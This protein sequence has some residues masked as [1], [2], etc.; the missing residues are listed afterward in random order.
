MQKRGQS[1]IKKLVSLFAAMRSYNL[2]IIALAQYLS[3]VFIF[4]EGHSALQ[5]ILDYRL[6]LLVVSSSFA[7]A[8]GYLINNFYDKKKD[9]INKPL[10]TYITTQVSKETRLRIY[11]TLNFISV[12]L[13]LFV[14]FKAALF[15]AF[16]IFLLWFYSHKLK[17]YPIIGNLTAA[18]LAILPFFGIL[19][20]YKNF[21]SEIFLFG[22]ALYIVLLVKELIKDLEN[23]AGDFANGYQTIPIVY[24][25]Q[26]SK[27]LSVLLLFMQLLLSTYL[28]N[29][30]DTGLMKYYFY[31]SVAVALIL[32]ICILRAHTKKAYLHIH[33]TIKYWLVIGVLSIMLL[34]PS[35]ILHG[36]KVVDQI[37]P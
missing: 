9:L 27:K 23:L 29:A 7:I 24:G 25:E 4:G 36:K 35:V 21:T 13:A 19:F 5:I 20:Y 1:E 14:S 2:L 3:A 37:L 10:T 16:Y 30:Y 34:N 12:L 11:F 31:L 32:S 8:S 18:F 15:Y 22:W 26:T 17:R 28:V 6:L 33:L